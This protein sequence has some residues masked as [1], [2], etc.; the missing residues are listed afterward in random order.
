MRHSHR[1]FKGIN[2]M[3]VGFFLLIT[4]VKLVFV[5]HTPGFEETN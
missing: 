5:V 3:L 2:R 4:R 1:D